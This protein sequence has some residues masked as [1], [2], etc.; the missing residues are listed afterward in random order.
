M[1][2]QR[3]QAHSL[4]H[5]RVERQISLRF[6][7]EYGVPRNTVFEKVPFLPRSTVQFTLKSTYQRTLPTT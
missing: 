1:A 2:E 4:P 3:E 7:S 5:P 6:L